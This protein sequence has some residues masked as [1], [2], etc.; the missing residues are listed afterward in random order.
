LIG[1]KDL[2]EWKKYAVERFKGI[3]DLTVRSSLQTKSPIPEWAAD[4]VRQAWN[5]SLM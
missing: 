1:I 5:A 2:G 3:L 4:K